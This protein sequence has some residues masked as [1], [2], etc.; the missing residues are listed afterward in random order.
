MKNYK[1]ENVITIES[2]LQEVEN[3]NLL[4]ESQRSHGPGRLPPPQHQGERET[5]ISTLEV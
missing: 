4:Q 1:H 3:I 2:N 5:P